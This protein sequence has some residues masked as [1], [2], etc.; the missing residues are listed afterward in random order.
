[1][2]RILATSDPQNL[3]KLKVH[4]DN[5]GANLMG[6]GITEV[7]YISNS[8]KTSTELEPAINEALKEVSSRMQEL[9]R[10]KQDL[11]G[12]RQIRLSEMILDA[13]CAPVKHLWSTNFT[14]D[15]LVRPRSYVHGPVGHL[16]SVGYDRPLTEFMTPIGFAFNPV[17]GEEP[18]MYEIDQENPTYYGA[19]TPK[20]LRPYGEHRIFYLMAPALRITSG[21]ADAADISLVRRALESVMLSCL[22]ND[23]IDTTHW[24]QASRLVE[25]ALNKSPG[26]GVR[27]T[28]LR[29]LWH[30]I[31]NS[32][33]ALSIRGVKLE[34]YRRK[35]IEEDQDNIYRGILRIQGPESRGKP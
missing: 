23:Y 19:F 15:D 25:K 24:E 31:L 33:R 18:V 28:S 27:E 22:P 5:T 13:G 21:E 17:G 3:S 32:R 10:N 35:G 6:E 30:T 34:D 20:T 12:R 11:M 4:V 8:E 29:G 2:V 7:L 26:P 9:A 16:F 1:M 14:E